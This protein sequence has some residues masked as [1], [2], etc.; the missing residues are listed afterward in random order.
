M[1]K[2]GRRNPGQGICAHLLSLPGW[3]D[4][5]RG[6]LAGKN[7]LKDPVWPRAGQE[8]PRVGARL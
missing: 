1:L 4:E 5:L 6:L 7:L 3:A 2:A 8:V